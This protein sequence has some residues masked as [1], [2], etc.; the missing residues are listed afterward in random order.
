MQPL[1]FI[2]V[3]DELSAAAVESLAREIWPHYYT[4]LIGAAQV[5]YMLEHFQS[6][7]AVLAQIAGRSLYF[8]IQDSPGMNLGYLAAQPREG[9]LFLSKIYLLASQRGKG[10]ASQSLA[11]LRQMARDKAL[12]KITLTVHKRNPS[13][14]IYLKWGFRITQSLDRKSTR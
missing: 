10:Y 4:P 11:F 12:S 14:K 1:S 3:R 8:L 2:P 13:V 7:K 6:R 5:A 9:E